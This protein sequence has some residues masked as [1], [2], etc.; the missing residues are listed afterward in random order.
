MLLELQKPQE[1]AKALRRRT[2]KLDLNDKE[3]TDLILPQITEQAKILKE[4]D[5]SDS[6]AK[7]YEDALKDYGANVPMFLSLAN[8]YFAFASESG[9]R[10]RAIRK[11]ESAMKRHHP[12]NSGDYF[13]MRTQAVLLDMIAGFYQSDG[14]DSKADRLFKKADKLR[15]Q[16]EDLA[17]WQ[18]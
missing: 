3:R 14:Q 16:A 5:D 13:S 12:L 9:T 10:S 11:I 4:N 17:R 2:R 1:A 18:R 6:A 8:E 15:K 7:V